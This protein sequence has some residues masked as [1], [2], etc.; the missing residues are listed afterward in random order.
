MS[1]YFDDIENVREYVEL[2][3]GYDGRAIIER[4][5]RHLA[6]DATVLELGMGPGVDLDILARSFP[7]T[8]SD[9]SAVFLDRYREIH[10]DADLLILDALTLPT[11][12]R[13]DV[14]YSN[15]VLHHLRREDLPVSLRRQREVLTERGTICHSFWRGTGEEE[16]HGMR[17]VSYTEDE[18][19]GIVASDWDVL[20]L[21]VYTE[22]ADDDS[23]LLIARKR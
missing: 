2:A 15:K 3:R 12:R 23:I 21:G 18:V 9:T 14:I 8:G 10:P 20:E 13:F 1:G 7:V 16:H 22:M 4:L 11:D 5:R 19:R 17:F 6:A